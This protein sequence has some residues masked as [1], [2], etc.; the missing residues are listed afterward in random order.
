[1]YTAV[2][3][4]DNGLLMD[5]KWCVSQQLTQRTGSGYGY[6]PTMVRVIR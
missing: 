2:N 6:S 1:M 3:Q 5:P 4:Q